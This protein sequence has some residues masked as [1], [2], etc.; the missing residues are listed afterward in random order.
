[1][2]ITLH[3]TMATTRPDLRNYIVKNMV[4]ESLLAERIPFENQDQ[5]T[6]TGAVMTG[7]PTPTL[8]HINEAG[9]EVRATFAQRN[10]ALSI[11]DNTIRIDPVLEMQ[12]GMIGGSTRQNQVDAA[13]RAIAYQIVD[14]WYNGDPSDDIREPAGVKKMLMSD[15]LFVGQTVNASANATEVNLAVGTATDAV[16]QTFLYKLDLL[17]M[18]IFPVFNRDDKNE[19]MA[20]V[21]N[22]FFAT[23][24]SAY[25]RQ[26]KLWNT[27]EDQFGRKLVTYQNGNAFYPII[28]AG[29]TPNGAINPDIPDGGE[30]G[31]YII[32]LDNLSLVGALNSGVNAYTN[33]TPIVAVRWGKDYQMGSQMRGLEVKDH[34]E[35]DT[36][37]YY[38]NIQVRWVVNPASVWQ[39]RA[40]A[41]LVGYSP[42]GTTS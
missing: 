26:L 24:L 2:P 13:S 6:Q 12:K 28:D 42:S 5:L 33:T 17:L 39:K 25:L 30:Q 7:I 10:N 18:R 27:A 31:D 4:A 37:P 20:L 34:G 15:P 41:W 38:H 16:L 35:E 21:T 36:T 14:L 29:F 32:G 40:L 9:S 1:M 19:S 3:E 8:R 23:A 22:G 11:I